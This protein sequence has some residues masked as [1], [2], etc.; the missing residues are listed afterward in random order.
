MEELKSGK[1]WSWIGVSQ[2]HI[3]ESKVHSNVIIIWNI[4]TNW[5][6]RASKR[7]DIEVGEIRFGEL[8]LFKIF[9]PWQ[10]FNQLFS[11]LNK[12]AK[13]GRRIFVHHGH[14][15][16]KLCSGSKWIEVSFNKANIALYDR[17][18]ILNPV[19]L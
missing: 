5:S 10:L 16:L 2:I 13:L 1:L 12:R 3:F 9:A 14:K 19:F 11:L 7:D 17:S 4:D 6:A 18:N 8:V 15:A